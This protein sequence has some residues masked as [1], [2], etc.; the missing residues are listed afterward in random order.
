MKTETQ[1]LTRSSLLPTIAPQPALNTPALSRTPPP[2]YLWTS[3]PTVMIA[4]ESLSIRSLH[5]AGSKPDV[6]FHVH[7]H[8]H[9]H[10]HHHVHPHVHTH[11]HPPHRA[12]SGHGLH[13]G[14]R[15]AMCGLNVDISAPEQQCTCTSLPPQIHSLT[16]SLFLPLYLSLS[17]T[18]SLTHSFTHLLSLSFSLSLSLSLSHSL[19]QS[20]STTP[21]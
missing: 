4:V 7:P 5:G 20:H 11:V 8:T 6:H 14:V 21:L 18:H 12:V 15:S 16:L 3:P 17:S 10:V 9:L 13:T 2:C 19:T 1:R